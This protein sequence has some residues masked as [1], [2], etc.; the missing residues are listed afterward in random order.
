MLEFSK[1]DKNLTVFRENKVLIFGASSA[2]RQVKHDLERYGI[3]NI[4]A[5]VDNDVN[6][7]G[8]TL[9]G[10]NIM[11]FDEC[12]EYCRLH[13][14]VIIQIG[15]SYEKSIVEQLKSVGIDYYISY[16]EFMCRVHSLNS[17]FYK[18]TFADYHDSYEKSFISAMD[19]AS[20]I[21]IQMDFANAGGRSKESIPIML[22]APKVGNTTMRNSVGKMI[23]MNHS[24]IFINTFMQ[25]YIKKIM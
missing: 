10:L 5:F 1:I 12:I 16:S 9:E 15:S 13:N 6:K 7:V 3:F 25:N 24:Y 20:S 23:T 18:Q 4:T 2:G 22:S 17:Y 14:D 21:L 11:A 8:K 19:G